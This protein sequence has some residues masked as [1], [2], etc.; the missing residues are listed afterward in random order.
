MLWK[1]VLILVALWL[2]G[3]ASSYTTGGFVHILLLVAVAMLLNRIIQG[4]RPVA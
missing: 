3:V 2:V 1:I 4:L